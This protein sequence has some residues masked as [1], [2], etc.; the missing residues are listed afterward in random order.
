MGTDELDFDIII[1]VNIVRIE[2]MCCCYIGQP[3]PKIYREWIS[4]KIK[5]RMIGD[6]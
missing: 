3:K 2:C 4:P 1:V 6:R 5:V